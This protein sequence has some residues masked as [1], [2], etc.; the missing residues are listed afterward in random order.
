MLKRLQAKFAENDRST[1]AADAH[2]KKCAESRATIND[3]MRLRGMEYSYEHVVRWEPFWG[4]A[5]F[6]ANG[7]WLVVWG[8]QRLA[9]SHDGNLKLWLEPSVSI[10]GAWIADNGMLCLRD[11]PSEDDVRFTFCEQDG[12]PFHEWRRRWRFLTFRRFDTDGLG[13]AYSD[14]TGDCDVRFQIE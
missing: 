13:Y 4:Y 12:T 8:K 7:R 9:V 14:E 11:S 2:E 6:S 1:G 10:G 3:D 5:R